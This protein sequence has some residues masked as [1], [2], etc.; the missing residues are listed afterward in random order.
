MR[1]QV[2]LYAFDCLFLN[3]EALIQKPLT[4]RRAALYSSIEEKSGELMYASTKVCAACSL[5]PVPWESWA[6]APVRCYASR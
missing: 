5:L 4:E 3:G 2:C 1:L 6:F